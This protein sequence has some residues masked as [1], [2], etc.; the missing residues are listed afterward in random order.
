MRFESPC[1]DPKEITRIHA[2]KQHAVDAGCCSQLS[3]EAS[4]GAGH[5]SMRQL[6]TARHQGGLAA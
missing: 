6:S 2:L 5:I 1:I 4:S 3:D